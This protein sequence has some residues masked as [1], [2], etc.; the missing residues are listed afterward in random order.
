MAIRTINKNIKIVNLEILKVKTWFCD[1]D[2]SSVN[3]LSKTHDFIKDYKFANKEREN[4]ISEKIKAKTCFADK[5]L[6]S[7]T[8]L[9]RSGHDRSQSFGPISRVSDPKLSF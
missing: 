4:V 1:K 7:W 2:L 8:G 3:L 5:D 9:G 6:S